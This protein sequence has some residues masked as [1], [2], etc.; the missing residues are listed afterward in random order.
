MSGMDYS[1]QRLLNA[2]GGIDDKYIEEAL[3]YKVKANNKAKGQ[4][5]FAEAEADLSRT[6]G[7]GAGK[8]AAMAAVI[9]VSLFAVLIFARTNLFRPVTSNRLGDLLQQMDN[10]DSLN[11]TVM[12]LA[13]MGIDTLELT[14]LDR[15]LIASYLYELEKNEVNDSSH[16]SE[17]PERPAYTVNIV[18]KNGETLEIDIQMNGFYFVEKN[19][20]ERADLYRDKTENY[21]RLTEYINKIVYN[22]KVSAYESGAAWEN[23]QSGENGVV[24]KD[25]L[26]G[27]IA[28][29]VVYDYRYTSE[30]D[31]KAARQ[32]NL[33]VTLPDGLECGSGKSEGMLSYNIPVNDWLNYI[34]PECYTDAVKI[35]KLRQDGNTEY[36]LMHWCEYENA[37]LE[38]GSDEDEFGDCEYSYKNYDPDG[39]YKVSFYSLDRSLYNSSCLVLVPYT[40]EING[41]TTDRFTLSRNVSFDGENIFTD[42]TSNTA[43]TLDIA[44]HTAEIGEYDPD[45][46]VFSEAVSADF[47]DYFALESFRWDRDTPFSSDG[48]IHDN[49]YYYIYAD[50][51]LNEHGNCNWGV[52][53]YDFET[54]ETVTFSERSYYYLVDPIL[55]GVCDEYLYYMQYRRDSTVPEEERDKT[56]DIARQQAGIPDDPIICAMLN[57]EYA[58]YMPEGSPPVQIGDYLYYI[59]RFD[60]DEP[61]RQFICRLD[62]KKG[63]KRDLFMDDASKPARYKDG[64]IYYKNDAVYYVENP[65]GI[66]EYLGSSTQVYGV[67][68]L[69]LANPTQYYT[70]GDLVLDVK[71]EK[72]FDLRLDDEGGDVLCTDGENIYFLDGY[73]KF[74]VRQGVRQDKEFCNFGVFKEENGE[75]ELQTIANFN[76]RTSSL[77]CADGLVIIGDNIL[78]DPENN[79]LVNIPTDREDIDSVYTAIDTIIIE[80]DIIAGTYG[81]DNSGEGGSMNDTLETYRIVRNRER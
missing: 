30:G 53:Y 65:N 24:D 73:K 80:D 57:N 28:E 72:L 48:L 50:S 31:I 43:L 67:N 75:F 3:N 20:K 25:Y 4:I 44:S 69:K 54:E 42:I 76:F 36:V 61:Q 23:I 70:N 66:N 18:Y 81:L 35:L 27:Y 15:N 47:D 12:S 45:D 21:S 59:D 60:P 46:P 58:E 8:W 22:Y 74:A 56:K 13:D 33:L 38:S 78:Y 40:A 52:K 19:G 49:K 62:L 1:H 55:L 14:Q 77:K 37:D 32:V 10:I 41:E 64:I 51:K 26:D 17:M 34:V 11:V 63:G 5:E 71:A 29:L 68:P 79:V 9:C 39:L 2:I 6:K 16:Y 7:T